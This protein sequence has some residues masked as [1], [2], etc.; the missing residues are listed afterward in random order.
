MSTLETI[1]LTDSGEGLTEAE[2]LDVKVAV[3]DMVEINDPVV[4]VETQK[5]AVELPSPVAGRVARVLVSV[6]DELE[7]GAPM[8]EID[9]AASADDPAPAPSVDGAPATPAPSADNAPSTPAASS[10]PAP[11]A[12]DDDEHDADEPKPLVGYGAKG[13]S[14]R[15]RRRATVQQDS[16]QVPIDRILAKPPVRKLARDLGIALAD[17]LA[18]GPGG[19]VTRDDVIAAQQRSFGDGVADVAA[20]DGS[21]FPDE[22]PQAPADLATNMQSSAT[23]AM[24]PGESTVGQNFTGITSDGRT[25]RV[26]IR[27]VRKRTAEAMVSSAFTAP[28]VTV[29]NEIDMTAT[30]DL[31]RRLRASREWKD[32]K[33]SPLTVI[34]KALLV[35]IRRNPEVNAAWDEDS[36]EIVYKHFVN[37]GIAAATPR[38]LIVPNIKDAHL[39][40]LQELAESINE[41]AKTARAGATPLSATRGGTITITNFGVFGI[42][43]GTP[44][45]NPGE[46]VILGVGTVKQKPWVVDGRLEV[47]EVAQL[48]C[49]FDHRLID[50]ELG[51]VLLRDISA[52]LESPDLGLVWG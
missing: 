32:V 22:S 23:H 21:Y 10:D 12:S 19:I 48:A 14:S 52:V 37:L 6:G 35:A 16:T 13:G 51:S 49:S 43:S 45:L 42:D 27:S 5:S 46:S 3:G 25:T 8:L 30:M 40:T 24:A 7:V 50:G 41:L 28:H 4:E 38:G 47:R 20:G 26:P 15:R 36:Q 29:F 34:A 33:V 9:T 11:A 1:T 18:T 31:V 17:V 2:I 39:L 44:I